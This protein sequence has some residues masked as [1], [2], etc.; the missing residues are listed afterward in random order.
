MSILKTQ[1]LLNLIFAD[2]DLS[3][4]LFHQADLRKANFRGAK[5]YS[6][7]VRTNKVEGAKFSFPE[8][9]SLL[10]SFGIDLT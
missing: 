6:L 1:S 9:I 8:A 5:N 3:G 7:D 2:V 10:S 4:T